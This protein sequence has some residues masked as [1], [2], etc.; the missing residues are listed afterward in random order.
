LK[1]R[2][3]AILHRNFLPRCPAADLFGRKGRN[4]LMAQTLPADERTTVESV[5]REL[6]HVAENLPAI[7]RDLRRSR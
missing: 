7:D 6:D 5:P 2:I 4:W 3:H 1:N